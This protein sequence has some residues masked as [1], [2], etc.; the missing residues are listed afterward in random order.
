MLDALDLCLSCK[1]CTSEC[2][3]NV[4]MPT[5]KAE[6][7]SHHYAHRLRPRHAYAFG[8]IDRWAALASHAPSVANLLT[9]APGLAAV[10][11]TAAGVAP[12]RRLPRFAGVT[13]QAWA[14][15]RRDGDGAG[16]S[17][18][19]RRVILWPDTFTNRFE[20][21]IGVAAYETL[22]AAGFAVEIPQGRL[23]CGRPL[24]DY[25]F[26]DL[27]RAYLERTLDALRDEIRA[28]VPVVGIEPSCVAVFRDELTKM[29]P[30]DEDAR[31]L[32]SQTFHFAEFLAATEDFEPPPLERRALLHGH[33]HARATN[34]VDPERAFLERMG[35]ELDAPE[36]G[37]C[38][39]AGAW[40]YERAHYDVSQACG[41]RVLLPAVRDAAPQTLIV[42]DGFSCRHQIEQGRT[43][44]RALH[45]AQ[46]LALAREF[47]PSGPPG[48]LPERHAHAP[49][50]RHGHARAAAFA[51]AGVGAAAAGL[52]WSR[53]RRS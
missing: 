16:A 19:A 22:E 32:A 25:G 13:L 50:R 9:Q 36:S 7:L 20:P 53:R 5:L 38:G 2:P 24:Y 15:R 12:Q 40:G 4:D 46:V 29:L 35:V 48:A 30:H 42:A 41:E 49:R 6:Y 21:E 18:G 28:G 31:R 14:R 17:A 3:V 23:C 52:A 51:G 26:L 37:C 1:G 33:C 11:K 8:L 45:L 44:R 27:A 34:G 10:A 39:M 47:G 43:G